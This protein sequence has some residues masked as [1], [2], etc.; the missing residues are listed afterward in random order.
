MRGWLGRAGSFLAASLVLMPLIAQAQDQASRYQ[1]DPV[2]QAAARVVTVLAVLGI[3]VLIISIVKFKGAAV[4]PVSWGL[5]IAGAVALPLLMTGVGTILVFERAERVEFCASCHLTMKAFVD[6]MKNPQS[7]SLAALHY[8]NRYIPDNQ[9]Y[10]C[11][12]S[13]GLFGTVQAKRE[14]LSDV[15]HY[16]TRTFHLPIKLMHPYPNND[17][18]KC[19]AGSAKWND[20]HADYKDALFS[21]EATC[22]QCH[23]DSNPAH[24]V[25]QN[26]TP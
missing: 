16:Y 24:N 13:Y 23:A 7:N 1:Q 10:A 15:Y 14:G 2:E 25:A 9:C 19:H 3:V 12:T 21:G 8:K 11:H 18:L 17:C 26:V 6:D 20:A 22:M 5:L 4:G